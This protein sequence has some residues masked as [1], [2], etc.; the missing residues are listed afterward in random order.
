MNYVV[1][2]DVKRTFHREYNGVRIGFVG[3]DQL[4]AYLSKD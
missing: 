1:A 2:N 3:L 4:I